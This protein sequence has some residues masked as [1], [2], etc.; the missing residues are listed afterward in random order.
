MANKKPAKIGSVKPQVFWSAKRCIE[1]GTMIE[2]M[3]DA[4]RVLIKSFVGP[5]GAAR[6]IWRHKA[7][8]CA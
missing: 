1:C 7:G 4:E 3:K 8:K 5:K 2:A 6:F